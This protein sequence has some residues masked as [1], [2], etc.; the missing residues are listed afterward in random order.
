MLPPRSRIRTDDAGWT[1]L[2]P[3]RRGVALAHGLL[4]V[5]LSVLLVVGVAAATLAPPL[6]AVA[7]VAAVLGVAIA[8]L[9]RTWRLTRGRVAVSALGLAVVRPADVDQMSW[10]A[11]RAVTGHRAGRRVRVRIA[12][13]DGVVSPPTAFSSGPAQAWLDVCRQTARPDVVQH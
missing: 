13:S 9:R 5:V 12:T 10:S 6:V 7:A 4:S 2:E 8:A 1:W 3:E 11:V